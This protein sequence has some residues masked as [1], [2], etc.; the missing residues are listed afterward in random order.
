MLKSWSD[1]DAAVAVLESA[2]S[3]DVEDVLRHEAVEEAER[4][5]R[6]VAVGRQVHAQLRAQVEQLAVVD[7]V[8]RR[9]R[10]LRYYRLHVPART[11]VVTQLYDWSLSI[12]KIWFIVHGLC[13]WSIFYE[14]I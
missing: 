9:R 6:H 5:Q 12:N 14:I 3:V 7:G 11:Q 4:R 8:H 2:V 10:H 1:Q 13:D